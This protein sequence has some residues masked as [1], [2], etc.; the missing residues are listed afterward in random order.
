M[1]RSVIEKYIPKN[2]QEV[3]DKEAILSFINKNTDVLSRDNLIAHLTTSAFIVNK[4]MTR[5]V[6]AY[7]LIYESWAW[8]GGHN[9]N[10]PDCLK[11]AIQETNEET[12]LTKVHPFL[13]EPIMIDVIH[14]DNH[15]KNNKYVPD[16][17]HLN[18][19]YL[20]IADENEPLIVNNLENSGVKWFLLEDM[21]KVTNEERMRAVYQKAY[22][23]IVSYRRQF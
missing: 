20:L 18:L 1:Y 23:I 10:E 21:A 13:K 14:V 16:H 4:E 9:D 5:V 7:H 8:I 19:T 11:V 17:L 2:E 6:F 15:I 3:V 12:G 22:D